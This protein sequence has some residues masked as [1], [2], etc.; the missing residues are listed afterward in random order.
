MK[1][2][3]LGAS[4][5]I[6]SMLFNWLRCRYHAVGTSRKSFPGILQFDPFTD[7]WSR[8]G[9]PDVLINCIGAIEASPARLRKVHLELARLIIANYRRIAS[10]RI[11]QMSALGATSSHHVAFHSTKGAAD[12]E[13]LELPE[14]IIV[15]PSIVCTKNTMILRKLK[16]AHAVGRG[17]GGFLVVPRGFLTTRVQPIM[18]NDLCMIVERACVASRCPRVI[19]AVGPDRFTFN[20]LLAMMSHSR[21]RIRVVELPRFVMDP[22]VSLLRLFRP[23]LI[24][25]DQYKLIFED[26]IADERDVRRLLGKKGEPTETFF[27]NELNYGTY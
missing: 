23:G 11:I 10:P 26:N 13:L 22:I 20:D 6:G 8:L 7:D 19:N 18:P 2:V 4:G 12:R 24:S 16:L 17:M 21:R 3:I 9:K 15:R 14:T 1:I 27:C 5:Q 25:L